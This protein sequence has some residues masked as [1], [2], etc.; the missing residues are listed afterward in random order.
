[1]MNKRN[2]HLTIN[3]VIEIRKLYKTGKYTQKELAYKYNISTPQICKI[4]NK[5][6]WKLEIIEKEYYNTN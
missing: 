3:S 2:A 4:I 1:M 5:K 6:H